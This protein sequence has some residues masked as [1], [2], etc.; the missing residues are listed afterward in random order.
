[1]EMD[2]QLAKEKWK[3]YGEGLQDLRMQGESKD[4]DGNE[5][6]IANKNYKTQLESNKVQKETSCKQ[7]SSHARCKPKM[8]PNKNAR[9]KRKFMKETCWMWLQA[10]G[11][12]NLQRRHIINKHF[13]T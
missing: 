3:D 5:L 13:K 11:G 2:T 10:N 9:R 1:M 12:K 6:Q 4:H 8:K 7:T